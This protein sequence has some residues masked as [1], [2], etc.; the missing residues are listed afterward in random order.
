M[1]YDATPDASGYY[2]VKI[3]L[4]KYNKNDGISYDNYDVFVK[5]NVIQSN[6]SWKASISNSVLSIAFASQLP[7]NDETVG[8]YVSGYETSLLG[9][10]SFE[11]ILDTSYNNGFTVIQFIVSN[12]LPATYDLVKYFYKHTDLGF[13]PQYPGIAGTNKYHSNPVIYADDFYKMQLYTQPSLTT[14]DFIYEQALK[15]TSPVSGVYADMNS[16]AFSAISGVTAEEF[17]YDTT[18]YELSTN[19]SLSSEPMKWFRKYD[20]SGDYTLVSELSSGIDLGGATLPPS[21]YIYHAKEELFTK[22]NNA[23]YPILDAAVSKD[24]VFDFFTLSSIT[25][26]A[27]YTY[28]TAIKNGNDVYYIPYN[29]SDLLCCNTSSFT[30]VSSMPVCANGISYNKFLGAAIITSG[31]DKSIVFASEHITGGLIKNVIGTTTFQYIP[32]I[33]PEGD[34][35][36]TE[37]FTFGGITSITDTKIALTNGYNQILET[38]YNLGKMTYAT[39]STYSGSEVFVINYAYLNYGQ[40]FNTVL[41]YNDSLLILCPHTSIY[42]LPASIGIL[43]IYN[44][45]FEPIAISSYTGTDS[46]EYLYSDVEKFGDNTVIFSPFNATN[47][48]KIVNIDSPDRIIT[49]I[50]LS[51]STYNFAATNNAANFNKVTNVNEVPLLTPFNSTYIVELDL[52]NNVP[53]KYAEL[54]SNAEYSDALALDSTSVLLVPYY[55]RAA[56]IWTDNNL[57]YGL[58][59]LDNNYTIKVYYKSTDAGVVDNFYFIGINDTENTSATVLSQDGVST[60]FIYNYRG[61]EKVYNI[62]LINKQKKQFMI[63]RT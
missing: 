10:T 17:L 36:S 39:L 27:A 7:K 57:S 29:A 43:D 20:L 45:S 22:H 35:L 11:N 18:T 60:S 42:G 52:V 51:S 5:Y 48:L 16:I 62:T 53:L 9:K 8:N 31:S 56:T 38:D 30:N 33:S 41:K 4:F 46:A 12:G 13:Y 59:E 37:S 61:I 55:N 63:E 1:K 19:P 58:F 21:S 6:P 25:T 26:T 3:Y 23:Y 54:E 14:D 34:S 32:F 40:T 47:I 2:K 44:D 15:S 49:T 24:A 28:S 50:P